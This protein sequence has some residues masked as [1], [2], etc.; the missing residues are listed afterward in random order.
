MVL[1]T[2]F[3]STKS[4]VIIGLPAYKDGRLSGIRDVRRVPLMPIEEISPEKLDVLGLLSDT[5]W[6][7]LDDLAK[8]LSKKSKAGY[9]SLKSK[10]SFHLKYLR[11]KNFVEAKRDKK[12]LLVKLSGLG[13]VYYEGL[14]K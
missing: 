7:S 10:I 8:E 9:N 2:S 4:E 11:K 5:D 6:K 14:K 1:S 3:L 12:I 13:K